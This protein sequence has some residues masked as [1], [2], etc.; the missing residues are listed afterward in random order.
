MTP[1]IRLII[2]SF[3]AGTGTAF[4]IIVL[5]FATG[6][7][8]GQRCERAYHGASPF[9]IDRCVQALNEGRPL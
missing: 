5:A 6:S 7:T 8:F 2:V 9:V 4:A 1:A 3:A